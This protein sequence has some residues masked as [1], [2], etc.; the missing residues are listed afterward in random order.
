MP[1][2]SLILIVDDAPLG[3]ETLASLLAIPDY[4]LAFAGDGPTALAM[5]EALTPDLI[6]LDVMMPGMSGFDVCRQLRKHPRL[7]EVPIILVTAL[8][9]RESR[10]EGLDAGAD[11][12]VTKPIDRAELRVRVRTVTRLNR[13][14]RLHN[15]RARFEWVVDQATQGYLILGAQGEIRYANQSARTLLELGPLDTYPA[16]PRLRDIV[17]PHFRPEP[18]DIWQRWL[19]SMDSPPQV[20]LYL[21][22]ME[23]E[24][25]AALWLELTALAQSDRNGLEQLVSIRDITTQLTTQRD[26]WTFHSM[27]MHKLNTPLQTVLGGLEL[28]SSELIDEMS[29]EEMRTLALLAQGGAHRLGATIADIL[30]YIKAPVIARAGDGVEI[31]RLPALVEQIAADLGLSIQLHA[32]PNLDTRK[33]HLSM[34][35]VEC[36]LW[37]LLEN[38]QK[39]HPAHAP[40]VIV[41]MAC[42]A[43]DVLDLCVIDNGITLSPEQ[44]AR[45]WMPYYQAE[46]HFT[47][48]MPGIGLGLSMVAALVWECGGRCHFQNRDGQPGVKVQLQLPVR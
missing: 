35:A 45:V 9:D 12:F 1:G 36:L 16:P 38:A 48:E 6:L 15:E 10:L 39:F 11:D 2:K 30:Q 17:H 14:R 27:V 46:K 44:V 5:S 18:A 42:D 4:E 47:G 37:E 41:N 25:A 29:K 34:R 33:L 26:T 22:R 7:S 19:A 28:I 40:E 31:Q 43:P 13:Y 32:D 23:T 8:D 3:R 20:P 24:L 21:I